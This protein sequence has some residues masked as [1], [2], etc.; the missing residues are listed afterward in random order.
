MTSFQFHFPASSGPTV[1]IPLPEE[2]RGDDIEV[3]V[4]RKSDRL[5]PGC[6]ADFWRKKSLDEIAAEQGGPKICTDPNSLWEGFPK[7]WDTQEELEEFL[8][9]RKY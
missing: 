2:L 4:M 9:R 8:E 7:L 6:D 5:K 3:I 1:T